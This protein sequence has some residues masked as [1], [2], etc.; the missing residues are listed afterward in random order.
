MRND[1]M[2]WVLMVPGL[3]SC[4]CFAFELC[5]NFS[6]TWN[7]HFEAFRRGFEMIGRYNVKP[8]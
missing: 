1:N 3:V 8:W 7:Q 5:S 4:L 6:E 2:F